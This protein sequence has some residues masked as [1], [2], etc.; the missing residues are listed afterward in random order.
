M[1]TGVVAPVPRFWG[2]NM[3]GET[4]SPAGGL[5]HRK[6]LVVLT[7]WLVVLTILKNISQWEG[8]SH[9]W[10]I[11]NLWNHQPDYDYY[12][13]VNVYITMENHHLYEKINYKWQFSIA[14]LVYQRVNLGEWSNGMWVRFDGRNYSHKWR[15]SNISKQFELTSG[16]VLALGW[17]AD[18]TRAHRHRTHSH[19]PYFAA[20]NL[21][22]RFDLVC[23]HA[24]NL[25]HTRVS[26][27]R[28]AQTCRWNMV[29]QHQPLYFE[30]C[31]LSGSTSLGCC[32]SCDLF[33]G[34]IKS[35]RWQFLES[36]NSLG[37]AIC[38]NHAVAT[39]MS[40]P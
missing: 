2:E 30:P 14:M 40:P 38:K 32:Q 1:V 9:I 33:K 13:L 34:H 10:K 28:W 23:H 20:T 35:I 8:L 18:W 27:L 37:P 36:W 24:G 31:P 19:S 15:I 25:G 7:I 16:L 39:F 22:N 26:W 21:G 4:A 29:K 6:M 3:A 12:P 11:K 17:Q 5:K